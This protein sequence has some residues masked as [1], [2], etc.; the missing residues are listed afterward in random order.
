[1]TPDRFGLYVHIPF[2]V[3][4]CPYCD[5]NTFAV[6]REAVRT[7]LDALRRELELLATGLRLRL[8][9][10]FYRRRNA[11]G[12]RPQLDVIGWVRDTVGLQPDGSYGRGQSGKREVKGLRAMEAREWRQPRCAEPVGR[13][14][15]ASGDHGARCTVSVKQIREAGIPSV[16]FDLMY[17]LPGQTPSG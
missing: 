16:N 14:C 2:C 15:S 7:F 6:E 12:A 4:K 13:A 17:G 5:F 1:M 9:T 11:H 3:R 10:P 8:S